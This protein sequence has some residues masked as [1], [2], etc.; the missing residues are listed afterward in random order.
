MFQSPRGLHWVEKEFGF[1]PS[2]GF[3]KFKILITFISWEKDTSLFVHV[4]FIPQGDAF[5]NPT[6]CIIDYF[7]H[8]TLKDYMLTKYFSILILTATNDVFSR[9][10]HLLW[11]EYD[12]LNFY[13]RKVLF[14]ICVIHSILYIRYAFQFYMYN[15]FK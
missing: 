9:I 12:K 6:K 5:Y 4:F 7:D 10:N 3:V 1:L 14:W 8:F 13:L 11:Y 15:F 2:Q